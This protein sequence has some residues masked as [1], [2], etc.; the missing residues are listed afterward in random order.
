M[1]TGKLVSIVLTLAM[2]L[3]VL[4]MSAMADGTNVKTTAEVSVAFTKDDDKVASVTLVTK[5]NNS[6]TLTASNFSGDYNSMTLTAKRW[7]SGDAN[8]SP[9]LNYKSKYD[10]VSGS[11]NN[12]INTAINN[13]FKFGTSDDPSSENNNTA[14]ISVKVVDDGTDMTAPATYRL[15]GD[16]GKKEMTA[17]PGDDGTEDSCSQLVWEAFSATTHF[18]VKDDVTTGDSYAILPVGSKIVAGL[19]SMTVTNKL[20]LDNLGDVDGLVGAYQE[21]V[22]YEGPNDDDVVPVTPVTSV[23]VLLKAGAQLIVGTRKVQLLKDLTITLAGG[24]DLSQDTEFELG[25]VNSALYEKKVSGNSVADA[26]LNN[27][28]VPILRSIEGKTAANNVTL[29]FTFEDAA[30]SSAAELTGTTEGT[31]ITTSAPVTLGDPSTD[32][33]SGQS[34]TIKS[35]S[36]VKVGTTT[37]T[38][39][40]NTETS[41]N[42]T[43]KVDEYIVKTTENATPTTT[44]VYQITETKTTTT[45]TETTKTETKT[46]ITTTVAGSVT[47]SKGSDTPSDYV[48]VAKVLTAA[49]ED[50]EEIPD[51]KSITRMQIALANDADDN[52]KIS[53]AKTAV[54]SDTSN[55]E[56]NETVSGS[57]T[58]IEE[59]HPVA[60]V[61]TSSSNT[62]TLTATYS[63]KNEQLAAD[64]SF[65]YTIE[66]LT[67]YTEY[68]V[69]HVH[70]GD[71]DDSDDSV[72]KLGKQTADK[73]GKVT[74]TL[75]NFSYLLSVPVTSTSSN[76]VVAAMQGS[77]SDCFILRLLVTTDLTGIT[78]DN[79]SLYR[80]A[81]D[82]TLTRVENRTEFNN[83]IQSVFAVEYLEED[84]YSLFGNTYYSANDTTG[85]KNALG[86]GWLITIKVFGRYLN[87]PLKLSMTD[88]GNAVTIQD[89]SRTYGSTTITTDNTNEYTI[90]KY[91]DVVRTYYSNTSNT[92]EYSRYNGMYNGLLQ[93]TNS[94]NG[95]N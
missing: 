87:T 91:L 6:A 1:K 12:S 37:T 49:V 8:D 3:S 18:S 94:I 69:Y 44:Y 76:T 26:I 61:Y 65:Q 11:F 10:D 95:T 23:E 46:A 60:K 86:E 43:T 35:G 19:E 28:I 72:E 54:V 27:V 83:A 92:A 89:F 33:D 47:N 84:E 31:T 34:V 9:T 67:A 70:S 85:Y 88:G 53:A 59:V 7:K 51:V 20:K 56:T 57:G 25:R 13:I 55:S 30:T 48:N 78:P 93:Y 41:T 42:T 75:K 36:T 45:G 32:T 24:A 5:D 71:S 66:D 29:T 38:E 2:L 73:Y 15:H 81:D 16:T 14:V 22:K 21:C 64:A 40:T 79:F 63:I 82:L 58:K 68:N 4:P 39:T 50:S 80:A 62:E 74:V 77:F 17:T 52:E 90:L